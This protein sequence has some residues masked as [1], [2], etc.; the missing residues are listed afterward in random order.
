MSRGSGGHGVRPGSVS[1]DGM[2]GGGVQVQA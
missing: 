1:D 2:E